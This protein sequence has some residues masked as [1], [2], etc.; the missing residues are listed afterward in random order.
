MDV[1]G[2]DEVELEIEDFQELLF[3]LKNLFL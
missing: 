1:E 2:S 3:A